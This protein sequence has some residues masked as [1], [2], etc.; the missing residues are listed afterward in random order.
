MGKSPR[1]WSRGSMGVLGSRTGQ[2]P[3]EMEEAR[4]PASHFLYH[5]LCLCLCGYYP[6][7]SQASTQPGQGQGET[8]LN[9]SSS[10]GC[11]RTGACT[12]M[13][14]RGLNTCRVEAQVG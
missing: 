8:C 2:R 13:G 3:W 4:C 9:G 14:G 5:L 12:C 11:S 7:L 1:A 6:P 10:K